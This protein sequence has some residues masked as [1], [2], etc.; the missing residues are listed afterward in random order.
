MPA[1]DVEGP[2]VCAAAALDA[3]AASPT[4]QSFQY[5]LKHIHMQQKI[6]DA[7]ALHTWRVLLA[8]FPAQGSDIHT[9]AF[10]GMPSY[11]KHGTGRTQKGVKQLLALMSLLRVLAMLTQELTTLLALYSK[12]YSY[13]DCS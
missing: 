5:I 11:A 4:W 10:S 1:P 9:H 2:S 12:V 13:R 8:S 7:A 3:A 6:V